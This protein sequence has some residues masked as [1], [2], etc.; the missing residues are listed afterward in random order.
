MAVSS[1]G[2]TQTG[3][4]GIIEFYH[5]SRLRLQLPW[6]EITVPD[7]KC[8]SIR[9][10]LGRERERLGRHVSSITGPPTPLIWD[11]GDR[12]PH[13]PQSIGKGD[14]YR[15]QRPTAIALGER[16]NREQLLVRFCHSG[17]PVTFE[18]CCAPQRS[19]L[20]DLSTSIGRWD[21]PNRIRH[22]GLSSAL[23]RKH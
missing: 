3:K 14:F 18:A 21:T 23:R 2:Q 16:P 20:F 19:P 10:L 1:L 7:P 9:P 12:L 17:V 6:D 13:R 4:E 8:K 15:H 22:L 5:F 11:F